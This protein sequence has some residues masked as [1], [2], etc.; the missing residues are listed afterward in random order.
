M[1]IGSTFIN[2]LERSAGTATIHRYKRLW[3]RTKRLMKTVSG[4]YQNL[5]EKLQSA[6]ELIGM[7]PWESAFRDSKGKEYRV[8]RLEGT[9]MELEHKIQAALDALTITHAQKLM[10]K[11]KGA[12]QSDYTP[13]IKVFS[14]RS[15]NNIIKKVNNPGTTVVEIEEAVIKAA[16]LTCFEKIFPNSDDFLTFQAMFDND[17]IKDHVNGGLL[18]RMDLDNTTIEGVQGILKRSGLDIRLIRFSY[19]DGPENIFIPNE[20]FPK[21]IRPVTIYDGTNDKTVL[22][23]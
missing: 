15:I 22:N 7:Q 20:A 13:V 4:R 14:W 1:N 8:L 3:A 18:L 19:D 16:N 23:R 11:Y 17:D 10:A 12:A 6:I 21:N 5:T 2:L 9:T